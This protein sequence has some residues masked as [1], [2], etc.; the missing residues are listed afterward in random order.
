MTCCLLFE[1]GKIGKIGA[2]H[3]MSLISYIQL[4]M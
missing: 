2:M 3:E 1:A 4:Y